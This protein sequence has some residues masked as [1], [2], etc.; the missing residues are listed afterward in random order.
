MEKLAG[1]RGL[2]NRILSLSALGQRFKIG[3]SPQ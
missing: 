3:P 2:I 1:L